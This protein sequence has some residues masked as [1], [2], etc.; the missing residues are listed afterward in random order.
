[1]LKGAYLIRKVQNIDKNFFRIKRDTAFIVELK[2]DENVDKAIEPIK[3][4]E[5]V[6]KFKEKYVNILVVGICYDS[7]TKEHSCKIEKIGE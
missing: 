3:E 6:Q 2:R 7:K 4:K 5:Y 1:M